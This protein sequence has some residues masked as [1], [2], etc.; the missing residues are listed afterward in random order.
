MLVALATISS[1]NIRLIRNHLNFIHF[2][3]YSVFRFVE[4]VQIWDVVAIQFIFKSIW[5]LN[6]IFIYLFI[7]LFANFNWAFKPE[8]EFLAS[9]KILVF[10]LIYC[11]SCRNH[12]PILNFRNPWWPTLGRWPIKIEEEEEVGLRN[13]HGDWDNVKSVGELTTDV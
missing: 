3:S 10:L 7:N 4:M 6:L 2:T 12:F 5:H 13:F 11:A 8:R 1:A 9:V